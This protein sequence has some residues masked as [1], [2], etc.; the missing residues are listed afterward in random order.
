MALISF[1][2]YSSLIGTRVSTFR[3]FGGVARAS[4]WLNWEVYW[5]GLPVGY[6]A[7][8][9]ANT[10]V[11]GI[12]QYAQAPEATLPSV[13]F[14]VFIWLLITETVTIGV[15]VLANKY[16][17][18]QSPRPIAV[19][20]AAITTNAPSK[21]LATT[22]RLSSKTLVASATQ[23]VVLF[24]STGLSGGGGNYAM[25]V[26]VLLFI[27][28]PLPFVIG[29][30]SRLQ[31]EERL[32]DRLGPWAK[33]LGLPAFVENQ[34][35]GTRRDLWWWPALSASRDCL[36]GIALGAFVAIPVL[37]AEL[38]F[39]VQAAWLASILRCRPYKHT[40]QHYLRVVLEVRGRGVGSRTAPAAGSREPTVNGRAPSSS[41]SS[42]PS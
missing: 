7:P 16:S 2:Q 36:F 12:E 9:E 28:I 25:A 18:G 17:E 30:L 26:L 14:T 11:T 13:L 10:G 35:R 37:Q 40:G 34:H 21:I 31:H 4:R 38:I 3:A 27:E 20:L 22:I 29:Y 42:S 6:V 41:S 5:P 23:M 15:H 1:L 24:K 8:T 39:L 19:K 33:R 32:V